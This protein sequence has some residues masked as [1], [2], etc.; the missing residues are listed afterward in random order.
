MLLVTGSIPP[1]VCGV[2]DY[3]QALMDEL[4]KQ[5]IAVATFYRPDWS[6]RKLLSYAKIIRKSGAHVVNIQYPTAG[7]GYSI[8]PQLLCPLVRPAK[9]VITLHEFTRKSLKGKLAIYLFFIFSSWVIFT[10][11][12]ERNAACRVAPWIKKR[13]CIVHI[14][15]NIPMQSN[16]IH[17]CDIAY[18]GL[19]RPQKG[20]EDFTAII[21]SIKKNRSVTVRV[22]GQIVPGHEDY[23]TSI[24]EG[25]ESLG[26]E[27]NLNLPAGEVSAALSQARISLLPFPDGMSLRRGSALAAMGN[28]SLLVTR[29][30]EKEEVHDL[31]NICL[32][33]NRLDDICEL[34]MKA[35][36]NYDSY[37]AV[38][39]SGQHFS[40]SL[41]YGS[42]ASSY[43]EVIKLLDSYSSDTA[44]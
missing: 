5:N 19:I 44:I 7:Y 23:A 11:E 39:A 9:T 2:G 10:T 30:P 25:L 3:A 13:S 18:F 34:T 20:L 8:V 42:I 38:R 33:A 24:L 21:K 22:I 6:I 36:D 14:G 32:M 31:K 17:V 15:S 43:I 37:E 1:D 26:A 41:S 4:K 40:Q 16:S 28:G 27:I 29:L 35:L 12:I